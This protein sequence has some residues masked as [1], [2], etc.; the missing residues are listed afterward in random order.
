MKVT[1]LTPTTTTRERGGPEGA[2][3]RE[4]ERECVNVIHHFSQSTS[5]L[6]LHECTHTNKITR[7]VDL[8]L[9]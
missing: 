3:E 7:R 5:S 9:K 4:G 8:A 6:P 2:A 1:S